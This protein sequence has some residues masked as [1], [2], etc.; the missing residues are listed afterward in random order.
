M[1]LKV[2]ARIKRLGSKQKNPSDHVTVEESQRAAEVVIK[3][4][5]QEAFSK[6]I[7][8]IEKGKTLPS[9]SALYHL[10]LGLDKGLLHVGGRLKRSSL[11]QELKHPVIL[12]KDSYITKLIL[13]H[14]HAKVC[15]QGQNQTQMELRTNDFWIIGGSKSVAKLIHKC[16]QCRKLR[17]PTE[18]QRMAELPIE[19][20]EV[21]APFTFCGMDCFGPFVIKRAR[22]EYK[23]YGLI[24]ICLSSCAVHIEMIEDLSTDAFINALRCFISLRGAVRKLQCDH[25]TNFVGARNEFKESLKQVDT[26]AL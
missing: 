4:V 8:M 21:S 10:D 7:R 11:S 19:R 9:S 22:K 2:V 1:L 26:N 14:Y 23:R 18:E 20:V 12:S 13:S 25:G 24:F 5:Q 16:V 15:H 17:R 6:E 3:L